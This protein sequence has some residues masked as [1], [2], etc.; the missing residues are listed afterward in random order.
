MSSDKLV[1]YEKLNYLSV[2]ILFIYHLRKFEIYYLSMSKRLSESKFFASLSLLCHINK[3]KWDDFDYFVHMQSHDQALNIIDDIFNNHIYINN[4]NIIDHM[5]LFFNSDKISLVYKKELV[6]NIQTFFELRNIINCV[7]GNNRRKILFHPQEKFYNINKIIPDKFIQNIHISNISKLYLFIYT[8]LKKTFLIIILLFEPIVIILLKTRKI[9]WKKE[10]NVAFNTGFRVYKNDWA[11]LYKYRSVDFLVD[12]IDLT[13]ENTIFC[14]ETDVSKEYFDQLRQ[15]GYNVTDIRNNLR[16]ISW[17]FLF[18]TVML[19]A[20]PWSVRA[21]FLSILSPIYL[22]E[23]TIGIIFNYLKWSWFCK[24][25]YVKNY[26]LYSDFDK[27]HVIRNVLLNHCGTN[28]WYYIHSI[29]HGDLFEKKEFG[30]KIRHV[31]YSYLYYNYMIS[32]GNVCKMIFER[33]QNYIETYVHVGCLWSEHAIAAGKK[34]KDDPNYFCIENLEKI[35]TGHKKVIGLFDTTFG[36]NVILQLDDIISFFQGIYQLLEKNHELFVLF[37]QKKEWDEME[38]QLPDISGEFKAL[39][40][41]L[42]GHE[43]F[44]SVGRLTDSCEVIAKS[45]LVISACF[46]STTSEA[47]GAC[48]KAIYYDSMSRFKYCY[49]DKFPKMVAHGDEEL[50]EYTNY[51]LYEI[52]DAEFDDYLKTY[53]LGELD[54]NLEGKGITKFRE[55][56]IHNS[57]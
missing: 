32:W 43:R 42:L 8:I 4:K 11:F 29:H 35:N 46:T 48:K 27:Y 56:L 5:N 30:F 31:F 16:I 37:K 44:Y 6:L 54:A 7:A 36:K 9:M 18:H 41:K 12:G 55:I 19:K 21:S 20:L 52:T 49:F 28:V 1:I 14:L 51:W 25:Y 22:I 10:I 26:V 34:Q 40:D 53:V 50:L 15:R 39:F 33:T 24:R 13:K 38:F 2:I 17:D 23:T 57:K 45:D 47:L 3:I